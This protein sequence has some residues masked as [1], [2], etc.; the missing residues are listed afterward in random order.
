M[1][2]Q[3]CKEV[4][5]S[6]CGPQCN[7][8][9]SRARLLL[10]QNGLVIIGEERDSVDFKNIVEEIKAANGRCPQACGKTW[11]E[12][13][14]PTALM[15]QCH[16]EAANEVARVRAGGRPK[17]NSK[18]RGKPMADMMRGLGAGQ[19]PAGMRPGAS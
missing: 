12:C 10:K 8:D 3:L 5:M 2:P 11:P 19:P 6:E 17:R 14:C 18:S 7:C 15:K 16:E 1:P 13:G 4:V 9:E